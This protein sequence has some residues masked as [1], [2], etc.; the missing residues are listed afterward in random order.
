M[1][2]HHY[3]SV[4]Y[5]LMKTSYLESQV[6]AKELNQSQSASTSHSIDPVFIRSYVTESKLISSQKN[7]ISSDFNSVVL[8]TL[9]TIPIFDFDLVMSSLPTLFTS[10]GEA[11]SVAGKNQI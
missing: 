3:D 5:D 8:V 4:A 11:H 2:A 7:K 6:K 1:I 9:V 10:D